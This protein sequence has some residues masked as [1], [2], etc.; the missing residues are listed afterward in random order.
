[1]GKT[2]CLTPSSDLPPG[3]IMDG[4]V[5][6]MCCVHDGRAAQRRIHPALAE[7]PALDPLDPGQN[8]GFLW[9]GPA[10]DGIRSLLVNPHTN[11]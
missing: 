9:S 8:T 5:R 4:K 11:Q 10:P 3:Q 7:T 6:R 1:M 2:S